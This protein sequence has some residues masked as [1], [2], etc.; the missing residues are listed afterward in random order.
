MPCEFCIETTLASLQKDEQCWFFREKVLRMEMTNI[1]KF[2]SKRVSF[3]PGVNLVIG[4]IGSGKTTVA[5]SLEQTMNNEMIKEELLRAGAECGEVTC[6]IA[7][8]EKVMVHLKRKANGSIIKE[9]VYKCLVLDE[10]CC[11]MSEEMKYD[12]VRSL[13]SIS[14]EMQIIITL[15]SHEMRLIE[16][17]REIIPD[18]SIIELK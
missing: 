1:R 4:K 3:S 10:P 16:M 9:C 17:M 2:L 18:C 11:R 13:Q 7:P 15:S 14:S 6:T 8:E 5:W 12:F